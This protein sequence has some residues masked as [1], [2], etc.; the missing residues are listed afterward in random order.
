M[1]RALS[2]AQPPSPLDIC[3]VDSQASRVGTTR[4]VYYVCGVSGLVSVS[5]ILLRAQ[6]PCNAACTFGG[7][8]GRWEATDIIESD[9]NGSPGGSLTFP[10]T[11][12]HD[13][14][15]NRAIRFSV[16]WLAGWP[17]LSRPRAREDYAAA[18]FRRFRPT[19]PVALFFVVV[20]LGIR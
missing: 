15:G 12:S 13:A 11:G 5:G 6:P 4:G 1:E 20:T 2:S 17:V 10:F 3:L 14:L 8:R 7:G 16:R 19:K 9:V 18:A